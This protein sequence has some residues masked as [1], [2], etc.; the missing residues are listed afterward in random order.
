MWFLS[1]R[2]ETI[3]FTWEAQQRVAILLEGSVG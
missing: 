1:T 3:N 2:I